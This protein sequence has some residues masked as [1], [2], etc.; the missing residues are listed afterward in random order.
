MGLLHR[1]L[2]RQLAGPF[3]FALAA[4][5]LSMGLTTETA[6]GQKSIHCR[7]AKQDSQAFVLEKMA[8]I[9][10]PGGRLVKEYPGVS[11]R[12]CPLQPPR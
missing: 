8:K 9:D 10:V 7:P 1:Y 12:T 6:G 11:P 2:L 3:V 4:L 5:T